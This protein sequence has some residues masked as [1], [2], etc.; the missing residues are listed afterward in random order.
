[1]ISTSAKCLERTDNEA[2][3]ELPCPKI[4]VQPRA[5][6]PAMIAVFT[7]SILGELPSRLAGTGVSSMFLIGSAARADDEKIS[8]MQANKNFK[9]SI[10]NTSS[11]VR[12]GIV[13]ATADVGEE[14]RFYSM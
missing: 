4:G 11:G 7:C 13:R 5:R 1:M 3:I 10:K 2:I 9:L 14:A 6:Q 8:T 12:G